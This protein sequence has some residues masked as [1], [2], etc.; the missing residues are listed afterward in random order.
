M[1]AVKILETSINPFE[2]GII[3]ANIVMRMHAATLFRR[4]DGEIGKLAGL[5]IQCP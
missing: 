2:E 5:K 1:G 4:P 3:D